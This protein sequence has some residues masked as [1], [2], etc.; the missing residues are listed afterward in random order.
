MGE[1]S[2]V[3]LGV[4]GFT[5]RSDLL[6]DEHGT[7]PICR[8]RAVPQDRARRI[9]VPVVEDRR[10]QVASGAR[11]TWIEELPA[12]TSLRSANSAAA[13]ASLAASPV[14]DRSR[15][16]PRGARQHA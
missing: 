4:H 5:V 6:H 8:F 10:E 11:W 16:A 9:V 15:G 13:S 14:S 3:S 12:T 7:V 2:Q 1:H